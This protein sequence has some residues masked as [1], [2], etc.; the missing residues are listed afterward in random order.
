MI[1][2]S[3]AR[4]S[5]CLRAASNVGIHQA[6][7]VYNKPTVSPVHAL[8]VT[9]HRRSDEAEGETGNIIK[10]E[11]LARLGKRGDIKRISGKRNGEKRETN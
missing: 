10:P 8:I 9:S 4:S 5:Q 3:K 6:T 11:L 7:F 1:N 2:P